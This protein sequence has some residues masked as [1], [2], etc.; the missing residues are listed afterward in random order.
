MQRTTTQPLVT[1]H[2]PFLSTIIYICSIVMCKPIDRQRL[3]KHIPAEAYAH[4]MTSIAR[5][6]ISK[7]VFST[8]ERLWFLHAPCRGLT[9]GQRRSFELVL[10][11]R[12][13]FWR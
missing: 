8:I 6:R 13:E 9:K 12:V 3:C 10:D 4:N 11:N 5:Q 2:N 7:Q 1:N